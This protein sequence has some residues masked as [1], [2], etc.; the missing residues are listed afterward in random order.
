MWSPWKCEITTMSIDFGSMP[1]AAMLLANCPT[2]PLLEAKAPGPLP[3]STTT[4]LP[5][6]LMTSG[7]E[8][9]AH[10]VLRHERLFERGIDFVLLRVEHEG[11]AAAQNC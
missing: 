6:V 4:S 7:R 2:L 11:V 3:V 9:D 5:P 8:L 1:A 10:L